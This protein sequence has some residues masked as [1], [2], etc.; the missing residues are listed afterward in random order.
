MS[1]L[2]TIFVSGLKGCGKSSLVHR[3]NIEYGQDEF[4]LRLIPS[5]NNVYGITILRNIP[6]INFGYCIWEGEYYCSI[7]N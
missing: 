6:T 7:Y 2:K 3:L 1:N 4:G 5:H